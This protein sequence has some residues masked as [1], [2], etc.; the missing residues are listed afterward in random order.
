MKTASSELLSPAGSFDAAIAAFQYGADAVYLGLSRHSARAEAVNFTDSELLSLTAYAHSLPKRRAVYVAVNTLLR[1]DEIGDVLETLDVASEA[2]VDGIILQDLAVFDL[3]KRHYPDLKAHASTQLAIHSREGAQALA[4]L[5]FSRVV[6][7]RELSL[8]EIRD[9]TENVDIETEVFVHGALCYSYSGLCLFSALRNDRSGNR[10]RCAYCCRSEFSL[11]DSKC[12]GAYP[13][14]MRDLFLFD[15]VNELQEAGVASL[16][17][18]GRMKNPL[19]VAS[20]TDLYRRKLDKALDDSDTSRA[21]VSDMQTVFCRPV[22]R[23]HFDGRGAAE[24]IIDPAAVG[25]RGAFIGHV[26][27]VRRDREGNRWLAFAPQ[28]PLEMHDG[29]QVEWLNEDSGPVRRGRPFGFSIG[30]MRLSGE[31]T[32]RFTVPSRSRVELLLPA[33]APLI[34]SN[35]KVFCSSSQAVHRAFAFSAPRS[36]DL[37]SSTGVIC[38]VTLSPES[39]S[40]TFSVAGQA[41]SVSAEVPCTLSPAKNPGQTASAV[42][43]AFSRLGESSWSLLR[44]NIHGDAGLYAPASILNELRRNLCSLLDE[45][46]NENR[47]RI[48]AERKLAVQGLLEGLQVSGAT[49]VPAKSVKIPIGA[50]VGGYAGYDETVL[51]LSVDSCRDPVRLAECISQWSRISKSI[52][53]SLPLIVRGGENGICARAIEYLLNEGY[54]NWECCDVAGLHQLKRIAGDALARELSITADGSFYAFNRL[55]ASFLASLGIDAAV[56]PAETDDEQLLRMADYAKDWIIAPVRW[57]P[58][59]FISETRPLIKGAGKDFPHAEIE[60]RKGARYTVDEYDG[61]WIT[62]DISPI[63]RTPL[64]PAL[65]SAGISHFRY[66]FT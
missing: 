11:A 53:L 27:T 66:D 46:Y 2:G 21:A 63:D 32:L 12:G 35:A 39:I 57:R 8:R 25:H 20:V 64:I 23:L 60:D 15:S 37:R 5:G 3:I 26:Q 17:I 47:L 29:I 54:R 18:E 42:E 34:P 33:D 13:F 52:R 4:D 9:I 28:R 6:L 7:A 10:G 58:P 22:T 49:P 48:R 56:A 16:K 36:K 31:T 62:R 61:R 19:Y 55:S 59:L 45:K 41:L 44:L 1:D 40:G 51:A 14:S 65:K 50:P 24:D 30:A 38:D 43:K